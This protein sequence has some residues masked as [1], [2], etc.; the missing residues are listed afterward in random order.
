ML[1]VLNLMILV[2]VDGALLKA[3]FDITNKQKNQ[4]PNKGRKKN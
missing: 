4:V 3:K 1:R 2:K